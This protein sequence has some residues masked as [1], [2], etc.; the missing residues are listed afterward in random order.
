MYSVYLLLYSIV[1][2][3]VYSCV[4]IFFFLCSYDMLYQSEAKTVFNKRQGS[5]SRNKD[6]VVDIILTVLST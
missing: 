1:A 4:V 6:G 2:L 5:E 3:G